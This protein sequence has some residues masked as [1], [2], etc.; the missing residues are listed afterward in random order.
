MHGLSP[1]SCRYISQIDE[2]FEYDLPSCILLYPTS[3]ELLTGTR[4]K[5][6][7]YYSYYHSQL[8]FRI[9]IHF[10]KKK[11]KSI[12][13]SN[14]TNFNLWSWDCPYPYNLKA[15]LRGNYILALKSIRNTYGTRRHCPYDQTI[16]FLICITFLDFRGQCKMHLPCDKI[17]GTVEH[18]LPHKWKKKLA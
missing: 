12:W 5:S 17:Q 14:Q 3:P 1:S 9:N 10:S 2:I 8:P 4:L 15:T 7:Q 13:N 16:Y 11:C 18:T 6:H